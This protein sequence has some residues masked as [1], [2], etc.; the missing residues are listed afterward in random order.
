MHKRAVELIR[1]AFEDS[2]DLHDGGRERAVTAAADDRKLVA[3]PGLEIAGQHAPDHEFRRGGI[4]QEPALANE[5]GKRRD[6]GFEFRINAD[7]PRSVSA[8]LTGGQGEGLGSRG[9]CLNAKTGSEC[10]GDAADLR[11]NLPDLL[12]V[13]VVRMLRLKMACECAERVVDQ[14]AVETELNR[15]EE[16]QKRV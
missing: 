9:N 13:L 14:Q 2:N 12:F 6:K 5:A 15:D 11:N 1:A 16:H 3:E 8:I 7:D 4:A 10:A